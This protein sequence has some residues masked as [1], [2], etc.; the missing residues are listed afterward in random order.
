[1]KGKEQRWYDDF[2]DIGYAVGKINMV[3]LILD[4]QRRKEFEEIWAEHV[5]P[6]KDVDYKVRFIEEGKKYTF[7]AYGESDS[8]LVFYKR[9]LDVNTPYS[10]FKDNL[11]NDTIFTF[12]CKK[13]DILRLSDRNKMIKNIKILKKTEISPNSVECLAIESNDEAPITR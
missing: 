10:K 11:G 12:C 2:S 9:K 7:I 5:E 1:M 4:R 3:Y 8:N 6:V 13:G